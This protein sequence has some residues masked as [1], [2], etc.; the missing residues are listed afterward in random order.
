MASTPPPTLLVVEDDQALREFYKVTLRYAGYTVVAV[1]DGLDALVWLEQHLPAL[2]VLDLAL[3]RLS[4]RDLQRELRAHA[5]T[6]DI[7]IV[8]V[9]GDDTSDLNKS[10]LAC[11]LHKPVTAPTL[12]E[13]VERCLKK[14]AADGG[15]ARRERG[16]GTS[17]NELLRDDTSVTRSLLS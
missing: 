14:G 4:G 5:E 10:E 12:V 9:T 13:V 2:I 16:S 6:R 8:V 15:Q 1:E 11:V 3:V 7:P 17:S